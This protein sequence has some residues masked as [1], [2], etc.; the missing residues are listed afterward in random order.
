[1]SSTIVPESLSFTSDGHRLAALYYRPE[2]DGPFPCVVMAGGWCYV[3]ELAQPTYA[4]ALARQGIAALIFDYRGFGGSDGEPRQ[5]IDP[6]AQIA[7]YR[8]AIDYIETRPEIDADRIGVWG[9]SYS[10]GHVL[11]LGAVDP[12]V[13]ALCGIVPV[14]DGYQNMRLAHGTLGFRRLRQAILDARRKR[15][16]TGEVTYFPHQPA[17]E[18]ELATWPFPRSKKTFAALKQREAPAYIGEATAESADLLL[19]Y[20]VFPYLPRLLGKPALLVIAEGDDH[21]HWDLALKAYEQIPGT[22]KDL[23]VISN[24]DHLTLYADRDRQHIV[25][26]RVAGFFQDNL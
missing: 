16:A 20:S 21:T 15:R 17:E 11:I 18:G 13:K 10:G 24:A 3:K 7:D 23:L 2:G 6:A 9:I 5:H 1:M 22:A 8:N 4:A 25:A 14:T 19:G 12:R 26:G